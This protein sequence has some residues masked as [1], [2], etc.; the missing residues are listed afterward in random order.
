MID[1]EMMFSPSDCAAC[2]AVSSETVAEL[3]RAHAAARDEWQAQLARAEARALRMEKALGVSLDALDDVEYANSST[4]TDMCPW[5]YSDA[6]G[7]SPQH[8]HAVLLHKD[9]CKRQSAMKLARK[10]LEE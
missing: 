10:A 9:G 6:W 7:W 2:G 1:V 3:H 4:L 8:N 5:C